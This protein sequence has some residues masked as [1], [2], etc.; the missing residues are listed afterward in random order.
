M[1]RAEIAK[2]DIE[3]STGRQD[4]VEVWHVDL[5][6][7]ESV[8][9]FAARVDK[10][11]RLDVFINNAS[12]LMAK[13]ELFEGHEAQ[14]TVNVIS[15]LLLSVLILP[16]LRRSAQLFNVT[17]HLVIVSSDASNMVNLTVSYHHW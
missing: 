7:Y 2:K 12:I 6:A 4:V 9:E 11:E 13:K 10:L 16:A 15:T 17:P 1:E 5:S 8:K 14:I 3:E